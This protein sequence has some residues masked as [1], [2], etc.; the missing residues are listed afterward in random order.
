[1]MRRATWHRDIVAFCS[2]GIVAAF[3]TLN[4]SAHRY[5]TLPTFH[6]FVARFRARCAILKRQTHGPA[7]HV[8]SWDFGRKSLHDASSHVANE[9]G[10]VQ[11]LHQF[12]EWP[13]VAGAGEASTTSILHCRIYR[14]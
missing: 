13:I 8:T 7:S 9:R 5:V 12:G 3:A 6:R 1:M 2:R 14:A 10:V 4:R 11:E